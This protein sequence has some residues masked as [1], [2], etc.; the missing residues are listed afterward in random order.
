MA[1]RQPL[2]SVPFSQSAVTDVGFGVTAAT[3]ETAGDEVAERCRGAQMW[4]VDGGDATLTAGTKGGGTGAVAEAGG[5]PEFW[6]KA[7]I[8]PT[9]SASV[10]SNG[11]TT[12]RSAFVESRRVIFRKYR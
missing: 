6:P 5:P 11:T 10:V 7:T 1:S 9:P 3:P 12:T 8:N 2:G 4:V